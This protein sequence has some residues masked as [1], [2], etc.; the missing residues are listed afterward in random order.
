[1]YLILCVYSSNICL[2]YWKLKNIGNSNTH[3]YMWTQV[4]K[5]FPTFLHTNYFKDKSISYHTWDKNVKCLSLALL[6]RLPYCRKINK[7]CKKSSFL[8]HLIYLFN[9]ETASRI[10]AK[11]K[12]EKYLM[13]ISRLKILLT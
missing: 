11:K 12:K 2:Q 5:N 1:M 3:T 6:W 10:K 8:I 13:L 7:Y 4:N 9:E